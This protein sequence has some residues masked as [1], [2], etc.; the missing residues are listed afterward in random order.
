LF[1]ASVD[2]AVMDNFS[3]EERRVSI[4]MDFGLTAPAL[5]SEATEAAEA[6]YL[7]PHPSSW[8]EVAP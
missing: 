8:L 6:E 1:P 3:A 4:A 5:S 2:H 7:A